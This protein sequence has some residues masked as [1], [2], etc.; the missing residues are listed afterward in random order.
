MTEHLWRLVQHLAAWDRTLSAQIALPAEQQGRTWLTL[1]GAHLG[2]SWL[3]AL[4]VGWLFL[5]RTRAPAQS[6]PPTR[7]RPLAAFC[8]SLLLQIVLTLGI[9]HV[10]R[11][12]R[13]RQAQ[14]LYGGGADAHSFPSGHA[15]RMAV[16]SA[17]GGQL[18]P[19]WGWLL[20]PLSGVIG[21]CRVRL[22]IHYL[23]DVLAG[24]LLGW[25]IVALVR[26][27]VRSR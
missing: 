7:A 12:P 1:F 10:I 17:W 21:W 18:W 13:P 24:S 4:V 15:M 6:V 3:W 9:K 5:D 27:R 23:G 16:I 20:W 26:S 25:L 22:A 11:R 8:C 2:D 14:L 19:R